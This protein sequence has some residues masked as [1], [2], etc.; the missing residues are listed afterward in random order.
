M[1]GVP[2]PDRQSNRRLGGTLSMPIGRQQSLKLAY[3]TGVTTVRGSDFDT[4]T[5]TWQLVVF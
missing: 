3:S 2:S 5:A 4:F 1:D